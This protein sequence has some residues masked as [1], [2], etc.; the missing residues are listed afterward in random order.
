MSDTDFLT[1]VSIFSHMKK[2]DLKRI[3]S[4]LPIRIPDVRDREPGVIFPVGKIK[5]PDF[6]RRFFQN[7]LGELFHFFVR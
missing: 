2:R 5:V 6:N 1:E 7:D 3:E 4:F